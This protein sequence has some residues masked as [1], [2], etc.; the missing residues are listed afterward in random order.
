MPSGYVEV[1]KS[2]SAPDEVNIITEDANGNIVESADEKKDDSVV[3]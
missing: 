2:V 1:S 3:E